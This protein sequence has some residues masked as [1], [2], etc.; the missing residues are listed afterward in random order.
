MDGELAA[1]IVRPWGI[2]V[3]RGSGTRTGVRAMRDLYRAIVRD[4]VS[5]VTV[6]DGPSGPGGHFKA[7]AVMLASLS[8]APL[9]PM[10]YRAAHGWRLPTWDG[11][12][13]PRPFTRIALALGEPQ[14]IPRD[15]PAEGLEVQR[16][17]MQ[18]TLDGLER[19]A[20]AALGEGT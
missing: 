11:M 14:R 1:M 6:P 10:A 19:T 4:Q 9:F 13:I 2:G 8:G 18:E 12:V 20:G 5:P 3:I 7:G 16:R 15:L 17:R